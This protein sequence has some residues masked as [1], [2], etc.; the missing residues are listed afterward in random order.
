[1]VSAHPHPRT[2]TSPWPHRHE[3]GGLLHGAL[4]RV[5]RT[6]GAEPGGGGARWGWGQV[7]VGPG[8]GGAR[9]GWVQV[10]AGARWGWGQVEGWWVLSHMALQMQRTSCA[11]AVSKCVK[12]SEEVSPIVCAE[13]RAY[14]P[15]PWGCP[16]SGPSRSPWGR[17]RPGWGGPNGG[18]NTTFFGRLASYR[19][20][21]FIRSRTSSMLCCKTAAVPSKRP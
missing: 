9:W 6:R 1:M 12:P 19:R 13:C 7:G 15:A 16:S 21:V 11:A 14:G 5:P 20:Y 2:P 4:R 10:G 8:G 18:I 17:C 3:G